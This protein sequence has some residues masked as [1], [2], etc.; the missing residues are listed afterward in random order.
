M[1]MLKYLAVGSS[2]DS[3][4]EVVGRYRVREASLLP[5]FDPD[6]EARS[7]AAIGPAKAPSRWRRILSWLRSLAPSPMAVPAASYPGELTNQSETRELESEPQE[8]SVAL[9]AAATGPRIEDGVRQQAQKPVQNEFRFEN[10]MVVCNDLHDAD[11]EIV[12]RPRG[13]RSPAKAVDQPAVVH[14]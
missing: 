14:A 7:A 1:N 4:R 12:S 3:G 13:R 6:A 11:F 9:P 2:L 10:V 8:I 5:R